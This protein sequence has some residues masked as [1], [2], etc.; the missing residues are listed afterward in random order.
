MLKMKLNIQYFAGGTIDGTTTSS[1]GLCRIV[2]SSTKNDT[3][4]TS[5][6]TATMQVRRNTDS[7][8]CTV[9]GTLTIDGTSVNISKYRPESAPWNT[10]WKDVGS[11]TKTVAHNDDGTK[12]IKI[13]S[14]CS[15][16]VGHLAG[17]F[18]A[19]ATVALDT[20]NRASKLGEIEDFALT[21]TITIP[22]TKYV[23]TF[24]DKLEIKLGSTLIKT[25]N[26]IVN[27]QS[28][29]FT[30]SEQK[31]IKNLMTSPQATLSFILTTYSGSTKI[32]ST[33]QSANVTTLDKPIYRNIIKKPNG[34]YQVAINGVVDANNPS[35]L[36]VYNDDG[37]PN[38]SIIEEGGTYTTNYYIKYASGI[39]IQYGQVKV[40]VAIQTAMKNVYRSANTIQHNLTK[41]FIDT[42]YIVN[43]TA[44]PAIN[45]AYI[46]LKDTDY[47]TIWA[48]AYNS[49]TAY[50]R[51]VDFIAIGRWK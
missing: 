2:W 3:N 13:S 36:Q 23:S 49:T 17:K 27:G 21:D 47:F 39:M 22:I 19:S 29:S 6:V 46:G 9:S 26:P 34:H 18:T 24:T 41:R 37:T 7:T 15:A 30:T 10:T 48:V 43:L 44:N 14:S 28:I 20:I 51:Y 8:W 38:D 35:P 4:N 45:S 31:T 33:T 5:S 16:T 40:S 1:G 32:G 42:N 50:T 12:S 11:Y 25:I